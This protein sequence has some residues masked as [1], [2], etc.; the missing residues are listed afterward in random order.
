LYQ[1]HISELS[2]GRFIMDM[3]CVVS[4]SGIEIRSSQGIPLS[5]LV[6]TQDALGNALAVP[7]SPGNPGLHPP[8][9]Q[10]L[11]GHTVDELKGKAEKIAVKKIGRA[12]TEELVS[13]LKDCAIAPGGNVLD[14]PGHFSMS[15]AEELVGKCTI[16]CDPS[17]TLVLTP[18]AFNLLTKNVDFQQKR[19]VLGV[20]VYRLPFDYA[21]SMKD[22]CF[23]VPSSSVSVTYPTTDELTCDHKPDLTSLKSSCSIGLTLEGIADGVGMLTYG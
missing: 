22:V 7:S 14:R 1:I 12:L 23:I 8:Y 11:H 3:E 2:D 20:T 21:N 17:S 6:L 10:S 13:Y 5:K 9:I 19:C 16:A 15:K 4:V 18:K